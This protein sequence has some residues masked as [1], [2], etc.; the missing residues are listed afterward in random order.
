MSL[1]IILDDTLVAQL[2]VQAEA[3]NLSVEA[4]ALHILSH[5]A[6]HE[7]DTTWR[8]DNQ[9]RVA[10]IRK[11]FAEGLRA[12]EADEL[13]Q[14]QD[15][16]DQQVERFDAQRLDDVHQLYRQVKRLVDGASD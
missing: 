8:T 7:E 6:V 9:R 10:L 5:A 15:M 1:T 16:A 13:Q 2:Q 12:E 3:R 4:L 14:L 11:Q